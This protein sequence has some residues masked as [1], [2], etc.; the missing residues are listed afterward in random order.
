MTQILRRHPGPS[1]SRVVEYGNLVFVAGTT[2]DNK[3]A[4]CRAQ[5]EEIL[6][7]IDRYL[8]EAGTHKSRLLSATVWVADMSEKGEM[9]AAWQAWVDPNNKPARACV[10]ARLGTPEI[11]VEIMVTC[12]R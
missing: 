11:R 10:E 5:T 6:K 4:S 12:A 3:S 7:K 9:D 1:L 2:A 8:E